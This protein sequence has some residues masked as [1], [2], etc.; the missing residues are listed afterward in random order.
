MFREDGTAG[1]SIV[2]Q[3]NL[4]IRWNDMA[5]WAEQRGDWLGRWIHTY[6]VVVIVYD[7]RRWY[8]EGLL[9]YSTDAARMN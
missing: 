2:A 6:L 9:V 8:R 4:E 3:R 1:S 7:T 5:R